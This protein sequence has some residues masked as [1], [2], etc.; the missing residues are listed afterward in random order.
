[1]SFPR[2]KLPCA[3]AV[4]LAGICL[5]CNTAAHGQ[6]GAAAP[7][8]KTKPAAAKAPASPARPAQAQGHAT[9]GAPADLGP[10]EDPVVAALLA[11][12]PQTPSEI[13]HT[14]QLLLDASRPE[15]AKRYLRKL[16]DAKLD[17]GQWAALVD[18]YHSSAFTELATRAEL[19][20]ENELLVQAALGAADRR[21]RDPARLAEEIKQL[22]EPSPEV[23]G[24]AIAKLKQAH[25]A[26]V[27][28]LIAVLADPQRAGEHAVVRAALA[29]MRGDAIDP[30]AEIIERADPEFMVEAIR[31]LAEMR[32]SQAIVYLYVP[33]L[34]EE[35]D[36]RVREPARAAIKQLQ[37]SLPTAAQA[38]QRLYDLAKS[39]YAGKQPLGTD[40]HGR[41]TLFSW[42][43]AAKQCV[44]RSCPP[45]D[46]ARAF[47]ARLAR[48][49]CQLSPE[50]QAAQTLAAATELEQMVYDRGL[51]KRLDFNDPEVKRVAASD[52]KL[53]E[54]VL[55]FCL[56]EHH[57][58]GARAAAE[59]LGGAPAQ[60][61]RGRKPEILQGGASPSPLVGAA[62]SS[63]A[64]LRMAALEAIANLQPKSPFPGSSFVLEALVYQAASTGG[65]RALAVSPNTRTLEEWIGVLKFRNIEC[66]VAAS[67]GEAVRMA[68]RCPD[69]ELAVIDMA[70]QSPPAEEIVQ[71]LHQDYR[72]AGLRI[73]LVARSGFLARAQ[74][75]AESDPLV[76]AF[77]KPIDA[78]TARWQLGQLNALVP[79]EFVGFS[80]RQDLAARALDC[81]AKLSQT[82]SQVFDL[83]QAEG[84]VLA[85]LLV[86][87]LSGH[88]IVVLSNVDTRAS[89]Q[90]LVEVASRAA[91]PL[92]LRKAGAVAFNLNV[93]QFGLLLNKDS[94]R[95]QYRRYRQS[96]S[97]EVAAQQVLADVLNTIESRATPSE[98]DAARR[99]EK[100]AQPRKLLP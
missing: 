50:N 45:D 51:D 75:I 33:A 79:R 52:P 11:S 2:P 96:D 9:A 29:A 55:A 97:Q 18:E 54:G 25:S 60:Q 69:Y 100:P 58:A 47:A 80:E 65:R 6:D 7:K 14:A 63:D 24:R 17:D 73:A 56:N 71:Q 67:G 98:L 74:R 27:G 30:L 76:I 32:A 95:Q 41:V 78:A 53:I 59:I 31:A 23:R 66:D 1:M 64:R 90:A 39:Y 43:P 37:G 36:L 16:L 28:A 40:S 61:G 99:P 70:T 88:A 93:Q 87:R 4:L 15:L 5:C 34:A 10:P 48:A 38:A 12:N 46:A 94:I 82:P 8:A 68:W 86:P 84:A 89:Q 35:S 62:R 42:D 44:G 13:F 92:P 22:Q 72:T 19:R 21:L 83:Q 77:S 91:N 49:A 26:A 3:A 81:L 85:G 20:P 57:P